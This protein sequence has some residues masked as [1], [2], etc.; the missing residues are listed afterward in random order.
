MSLHNEQSINN[1]KNIADFLNLARETLDYSENMTM[2][3][4][5]LIY[6]HQTL[7]ENNMVN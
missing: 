3:S 4:N 5:V 6:F 1:F 2:S 7:D